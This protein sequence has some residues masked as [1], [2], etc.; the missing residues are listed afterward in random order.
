MDMSIRRR[1][2]SVPCVSEWGTSLQM[3]DVDHRIHKA[4]KFCH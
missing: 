1:R 4:S 2:A 3:I